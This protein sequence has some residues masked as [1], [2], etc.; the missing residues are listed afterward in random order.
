MTTQTDIN[1]HVA[2]V[3]DWAAALDANC[4]A[5]HGSGVRAPRVYCLACERGIALASADAHFAKARRYEAAQTRVQR[6]IAECHRLLAN[7]ERAAAAERETAV[8]IQGRRS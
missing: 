5:C 8:R 2:A 6:H 3:A 4:P 1:T 7:L